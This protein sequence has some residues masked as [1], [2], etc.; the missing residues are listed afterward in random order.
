[1]YTVQNLITQVKSVVRIQTIHYRSYR[2]YHT[3]P[4]ELY[5]LYG[6]TLIKL[7]KSVICKQTI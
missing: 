7:A 2:S 4:I 1:M 3:K 6:Q 5:V